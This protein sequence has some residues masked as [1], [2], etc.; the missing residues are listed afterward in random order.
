MSLPTFLIV[1]AQKAGTTSLY[2][3]LARHPDVFMSD[4]KEPGYFI[5]GFD[6]P[7][8]WQTLKR[9]VAG[10]TA[11]PLADVMQGIFTPAD[12][13]HLFASEAAR[14]ARHRGEASTPY[15]PSPHAA[16]RIAETVPHA[17]IVIALRDPVERAYS[18]WGYNLSRGNESA[19]RF[20]DAV[21]Q[22]L[23]GQRNDYIWGS[24]YLY[25]G[26]YAEHV[27][28]YLEHFPRDRIL[29][30]KFED[31]KRSPG[32]SFAKLCRF[33]DIPAIDVERG[34]QENATI[35]HDNAVMAQAKAALN[36]PGALKSAAKAILPRALR[37]RLRRRAEGAIDAFGARPVALDPILRSQL[38]DFF[39]ED[40]QRLATMID[41][42]ISDWT[43]MNKH[44]APDA[45]ADN[46]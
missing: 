13:A 44:A 3:M 10:G 6:D 1:G 39:A 30:L 16:A 46:G 20:E 15:L 43:P 26:L 41:F 9:P 40:C 42:D 35:M 25:S 4:P 28:R 23:A 21:A 33:L 19:A 31:F 36:K 34:R 2:A 29:F 14:Q 18:A 45:G 7:E 12:Y 37:N 32:E 8:R 5:R 11:R 27:A 17:R 24:R 38:A 22:E